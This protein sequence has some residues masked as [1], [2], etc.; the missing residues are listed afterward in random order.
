MVNL[1]Q[2]SDTEFVAW[3]DRLVR[4]AEIDRRTSPDPSVNLGNLSFRK[5]TIQTK[6]SDNK[7]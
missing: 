7:V 3:M 4:H 1:T 5:E 2:L 6:L